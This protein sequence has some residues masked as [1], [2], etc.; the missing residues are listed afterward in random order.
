MQN[1]TPN[2]SF[3][4]VASLPV[5]GADNRNASTVRAGIEAALDRTAHNALH[6]LWKTP[7]WANVVLS[8]PCVN[9]DARFEHKVVTVGANQ[10]GGWEQVNV[11]DEG[12]LR[13]YVQL[14][15][16]GYI[17]TL[18]LELGGAIGEKPNT[19]YQVHGG[20]LGFAP[21]FKAIVVT[22]GVPSVVFD[23]AD[24][25]AATPA[26]YDPRHTITEGG[27]S[28]P[29]QTGSQLYVEVTGEA[30]S[31]AANSMLVVT[32]IRYYVEATP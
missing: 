4:A 21:T 15:P 27:L 30:G 10:Y 25:A 14:P 23:T 19:N 17:K 26:L 28:V 20:P 11:S 8:A 32:A 13:W 22:G 9:Q 7:G 29:I 12:L 31:W 18:E 16:R 5:D 2:P 6:S 3:P 1:Y 24:T